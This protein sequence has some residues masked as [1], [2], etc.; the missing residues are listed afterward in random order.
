MTNEGSVNHHLSDGQIEECAGKSPGGYPDEI[1]KHL[2][3][4]GLCL[5]R[6]LQCQR[7]HFKNLESNGMKPEPYRDCPSDR[8]LQEVAA[9]LAAPDTVAYILQ[10]AAEC[11]HCGPLLNRYLHEFSEE[12]SP[13]IESLIEQLPISQPNWQ[14]MKARE[15]VR[16][17]PG[18]V[19]TPSLVQQIRAFLVRDNAWVSA[20]WI[21]A[22]G[23]AVVA[24]AIASFV[25]GPGLIADVNLHKEKQ[26]VAAAFAERRTIEPRITGVGYS[27]YQGPVL[28]MG[29]EDESESLSRPALLEAQSKL[30]SMLKSRS[31]SDPHLLQIQGRL[32]LLDNPAH[33]AKAEEVFQ[34]AQSKGLNDLSLEIDMAV[35]YFEGIKNSDNPNM[36]KPIDLLRKVLESKNPKP[37]REEQAVALFDLALAYEKTRLWNSA[38][39]AWKEYLSIDSSGPWADEARKH[40]TAAE[41]MVP[42]QQSYKDPADFIQ[43]SSNPEVQNDVEYYQERALGVW[44]LKAVD[45]PLSDSA[46]AV[47]K[48]AGLMQQQHADTLW[49]DLANSTSKAD[50]PAVRAFSAAFAANLNDRHQ[51]AIDESQ[52]AARI[53]GEH[54]NTPGEFLARFEEIYALQR[55]LAGD[56]CLTKVDQ[57]LPRVSTRTYRWL[58][59]QIALE[60]AICA[61]MV[62]QFQTADDNLKISR[63]VASESGSNFPE[64][65]LRVIGMEAGMKRLNF[66]YD[67]AWDEALNGLG[68]YWQHSYSPERL[69]Q[70]ITV[71]RQAA[72]DTGSFYTAEALLR[73]S[74]EI[75]LDIA[76]DDNVLLALL[77]MRMASLLWEHGQ[78]S[79]AEGEALQARLLLDKVSPRDPTKQTYTAMARIQLAD[80]ELRRH[81][82]ALALSAIQPIGESLETQDNFV[83][84]DFYRIRG[85]ASLQSNFLDQALAEYQQSIRVAEPSNL[86][87]QDEE[88]RLRWI[89]ASGKLYRGVVQVFLAKGQSDRALA[90]WERS[91][92]RFLGHGGGASR[93]L[94]VAAELGEIRLPVTTT[95]HVVYASFSDRMQVW[96]VQ[97]TKSQSRSIPLTQVELLR[98]I[99][100]FDQTC[101]SPNSSQSELDGQA[102]RLYELLLKPVIADLPS[103][104]PV[105]IEF[106]ELIPHFAIEAL[107]S[108]QGRYFG[109]EY[110]VL[111]SP[112]ILAEDSL[113]QPLQITVQDPFLVVDASQPSGPGFLPGHQLPTEAITQVR[114]QRV[115]FASAD[116]SLQKVKQALRNSVVL[117]ILSHGRRNNTGMALELGPELFLRSKDFSPELLQRLRLAVLAACSSGS[118]GNGL[119]D[120]DNLVR[121]LLAGRVPNVIASHWA[122]DSQSTGAFFESFYLNLGRGETAAEALRDARRAMLS[123]STHSSKCDCDLSQ[124]Y[125]WAAFDLTGRFN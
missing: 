124:P 7:A 95:P 104:E 26:R 78:E 20:A 47:R 56:D 77:H 84:L 72:A 18:P 19:P 62:Y 94:K 32:T 39:S 53:F 112:G 109:E 110:A 21:R 65:R 105:A 10:H 71:M 79:L 101:E 8:A 81:K 24:V 102:T 13:E 119:L 23:A 97:G 28:P 121:S 4:C 45:Q 93:V 63:S 120:A 51:E 55:K 40:L 100:E 38:I 98:M 54:H 50:L 80:F 87:I 114:P 44:W 46:L 34:R 106:D 14:K 16:G 108:P 15:I 48:V 60:K 9:E 111:R 30:A 76:P 37:N 27:S 83:K 58:Q 33:A 74:I 64:L 92:G 31:S 67:V 70:F 43:N 68:D 12:L 117:H 115:V 22:A 66:E 73:K 82:T 103:T 89:A 125:R 6:L 118:A 88:R 57:L 11:D 29:P 90:I 69:Y 116:P 85:D 107:K 5:D 1:E 91:S 2:S 42:K 25:W 41:S 17:L 36:S 113:R 122:V 96:I 99:R 52:K 49:T 35:S 86:H 123:A 3:G 59:G 61:N 75:L